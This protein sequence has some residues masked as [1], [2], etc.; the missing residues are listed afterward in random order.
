[1]S[2]ERS[3][4]EEDRSSNNSEGKTQ[5]SADD[6]VPNKSVSGVGRTRLEI[7]EPKEPPDD[8]VPDT[9]LPSIGR[10]RLTEGIVI[11]KS[12]ENEVDSNKKSD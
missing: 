10:V 9:S 7:A 2:L 6:S 3:E 1:M 5:M 11:R 12:D 8:S 4:K